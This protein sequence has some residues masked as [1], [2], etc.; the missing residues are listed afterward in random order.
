[1]T[2][3]SCVMCRASAAGSWQ[4]VGGT[5]ECQARKQS[6]SQRAKL[7]PI[8]V[9]WFEYCQGWGSDV[10]RA[11]ESSWQGV[12][13]EACDA[14]RLAPDDWTGKAILHRAS[15]ARGCALWGCAGAKLCA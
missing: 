13:V 15:T 5:V 4:T 3:V 12:V 8:K 11:G 2:I 10:M 9:K 14:L 1:M 7:G 6:S